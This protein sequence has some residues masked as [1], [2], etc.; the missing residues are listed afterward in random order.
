MKRF[1][2]LCAAVTLLVME[3]DAGLFH[4]SRCCLPTCC[5]TT[6]CAPVT[7][8]KVEQIRYKT[9]CEK[10]T[11]PTEISF[12]RY[13]PETHYCEVAYQVMKPVHE[14]REECYT[15]MKPVY[16]TR[17]E[18]YTVE[19]PVWETRTRSIRYTVCKPV[20]Y[21]ETVECQTY[22]W[23]PRGDRPENGQPR[24]L[25]AEA[26]SLHGDLLGPEARLLPDLVRC[27]WAGRLQRLTVA[28]AVVYNLP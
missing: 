20:R 4:R 26:G 13:V 7:H 3:A 25:R 19:K 1:V 27:L 10:V 23:N 28:G 21:T 15:V 22:C 11:E 17:E 24:P 8:E 12:T 18:S 14:T 9:V 6:C 2:V 5:E 16:E